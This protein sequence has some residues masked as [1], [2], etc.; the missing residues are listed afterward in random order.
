MATASILWRRLDTPGHDACRLER[1]GAGWRIDGTAVFL[2]D[3]ATA[4]LAYRVA[5]DDQWRSVHGEIDGW[6]GSRSV[7]LQVARTSDGAW[8]L[9]GQIMQGLGD[10]IDLDFGFTPATNLL[11]IRR[12]TLAEGRAA[13]VPAAWVDP[14]TSTI[15]RLSQRYER[16][17]PLSFWYE[18]PRFDYKALLE[19]DAVGF[20]RRYPG[21]WEA[22]P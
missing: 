2:Q 1:S 19:V 8:I 9:N 20:I 7:A 6:I 15:E 16:R 17:G 12:G 3:G 10:C 14:F 22:E 18:A 4:Q 21:L 5:C 11:Q 13:D